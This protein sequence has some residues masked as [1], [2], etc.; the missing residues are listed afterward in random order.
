[1]SKAQCVPTAVMTQLNDPTANTPAALT[2]SD[3]CEDC[4]TILEIYVYARSG[5]AMSE[6]EPKPKV[7]GLF[8]LKTAIRGVN[9]HLCALF[10][11]LFSKDDLR[12][13]EHD[14]VTVECEL[15]SSRSPRALLVGGKSLNV[16][17]ITQEIG[18]LDNGELPSPSPFTGSSKTLQLANRWLNDC[19]INHAGCSEGFI[20]GFMP[21]RLIDIG[22]DGAILPK[23]IETSSMT[24]PQ[25]YLSLSHCWGGKV[26]LSLCHGSL[27]GMREEISYG[28]L[29]KTFQ[30]ALIVTRQLN[31]RYVWIDSLCI[32]QDSHEDWVKESDRMRQ[33]YSNSFCNIAASAAENSSEGL[34]F[35]RYPG[36]IMPLRFQ[37]MEVAT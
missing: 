14:E 22:L 30:H 23:L 29:P 28:D 8:R 25:R 37:S 26:P 33:V 10:L 6:Q 32:I 1:M 7:H 19:A 12:E 35:D 2:D 13:L 3:I 34:F 4:K 15:S 31:F 16:K 18:I 9:C 27:V 17:Q 21:S 20:P 36:L 24:S 5:S 11:S